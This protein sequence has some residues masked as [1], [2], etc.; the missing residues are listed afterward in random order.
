MLLQ[1]QGSLEKM[2]KRVTLALGKGTGPTDPTY[3]LLRSIH[4]MLEQEKIK[5]NAVLMWKDILMLLGVAS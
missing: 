5:L 3:E 1:G 4:T 2:M